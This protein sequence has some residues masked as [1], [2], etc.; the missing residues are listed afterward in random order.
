MNT[1]VYP[2]EI[3]RRELQNYLNN[4]PNTSDFFIPVRRVDIIQI[5][6]DRNFEVIRQLIE[7]ITK[8]H[9]NG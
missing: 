8:K 4:L 2:E 1:R 3:F 5:R 9:C 6:V 7:N